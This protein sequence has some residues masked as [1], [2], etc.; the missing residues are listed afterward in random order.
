MIGG[1]SDL[2]DKPRDRNNLTLVIIKV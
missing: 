2:L 1:K